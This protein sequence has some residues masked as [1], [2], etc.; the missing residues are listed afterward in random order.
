MSHQPTRYVDG[1]SDSDRWRDFAFRDD[2]IVISTRSKTGTT[3]VQMICAL[4]IFRTPDLPRPLADLSPWLDWLVLPKDDVFNELRQQQHRRFIKTHT[5]LDGLPHHDGVTY[6]VV[7]R[8]P[9]D[10]AVSLHHQSHNLD[11]RRIAELSGDPDRAEPRQLPPLDEWLRAWIESDVDAHTDLDSF[12]GVF[13]HVNDAWTRADGSDVIL[14]HYA[15]LLHDL[16]GE[17]HRIATCLGIDITQS[18][19]ADLAPYATFRSMRA[20]SDVLAPA[21]AGVLVDSS[22]F[23]RSGRSGAGSE[24]LDSADLAAYHQRAA[25]AAPPELV[26]WLHRS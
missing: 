20:H 17:M 12:N 4:L 23:F 25:R 13:H 15:D 14:V 1:D 3:W 19:V 18:D 2:D 9:L 5:P 10:A 24:A 11:R 26:T 22:R 8:H 21:P 16:E 6:I 7:A